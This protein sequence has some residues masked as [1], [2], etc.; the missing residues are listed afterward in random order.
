M[1]QE[2]SD[3]LLKPLDA[4]DVCRGLAQSLQLLRLLDSVSMPELFLPLQSDP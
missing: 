3:L 2:A 4:Q 1:H